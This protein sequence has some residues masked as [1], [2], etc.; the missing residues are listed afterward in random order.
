MAAGD[1]M[2]VGPV[3]GMTGNRLKFALSLSIRELTEEDS[4]YSSSLSDSPYIS[5]LSDSS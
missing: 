5:S 4:P 2:L 1:C 3:S